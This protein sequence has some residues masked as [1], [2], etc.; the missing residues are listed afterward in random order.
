M[1][2]PRSD[3]VP[4]SGRESTLPASAVPAVG[5]AYW[6]SLF[7]GECF[8]IEL[9]MWDLQCQKE[10]FTLNPFI[11]SLG[12]QGDR[13][14]GCHSSFLERKCLLQ[15]RMNLRVTTREQYFLCCGKPPLIFLLVVVAAKAVLFVQVFIACLCTLSGETGLS[16]CHFTTLL[17][18]V[19]H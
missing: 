17:L 7:L 5:L 18:T 3:R 4:A 9:K 11:P 6:T 19:S 1:S 15:Q 8:A 12:P 10:Q 13:W 2:C 14:V 16:S